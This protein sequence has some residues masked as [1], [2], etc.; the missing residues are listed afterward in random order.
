MW[1]PDDFGGTKE[2]VIPAERVWV[3]EIVLQNG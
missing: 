1:N 2:L 3:P